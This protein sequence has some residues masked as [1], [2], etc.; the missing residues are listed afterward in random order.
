MDKVFVKVHEISHLKKRK[1]KN[2]KTKL[3][4]TLF[5]VKMLANCILTK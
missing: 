1:K 2:D 3:V 4:D 5:L